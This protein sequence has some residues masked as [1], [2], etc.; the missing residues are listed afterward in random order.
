MEETEV[1][2]VGVSRF[3]FAVSVSAIRPTNDTLGCPSFPRAANIFPRFTRCLIAFVDI[4]SRVAA[5]A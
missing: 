3:C 5:S 1:A 4:P 2:G